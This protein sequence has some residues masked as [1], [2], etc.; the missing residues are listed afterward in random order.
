MVFRS[1]SATIDSSSPV[2][3]IKDWDYEEVEEGGINEVPWTLL[4]QPRNLLGIQVTGFSSFG[5]HFFYKS[6]RTRNDEFLLREISLTIND[7]HEFSVVGS[8]S[9]PKTPKT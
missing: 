7:D 5:G 3:W 9:G 2:F 6:L 4:K 1:K 8:M